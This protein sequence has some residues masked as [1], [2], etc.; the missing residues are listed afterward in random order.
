MT[1]YFMQKK[2]NFKYPVNTRLEQ[3]IDTRRLTLN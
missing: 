3:A 2:L 1:L